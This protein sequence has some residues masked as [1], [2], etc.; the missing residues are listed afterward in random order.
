[1]NHFLDIHT[2]DATALRGIIDQARSMKGCPQGATQRHARCR[3][4]VEK[5]RCGVDF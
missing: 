1:M 4:T 2:T 3:T 5:S